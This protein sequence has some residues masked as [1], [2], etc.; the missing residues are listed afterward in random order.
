MAAVLL[1]KDSKVL[2]CNK[3][4]QTDRL[5]GLNTHIQKS[6]GK[7]VEKKK[8]VGKK[9]WQGKRLWGNR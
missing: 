3:F 6:A 9:K 8:A 7:K 5:D 2:Q 4:E 1:F